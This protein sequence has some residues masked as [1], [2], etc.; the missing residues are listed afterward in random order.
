[1]KKLFIFS[2]LML[3][4]LCFIE[5]YA[6]DWVKQEPYPTFNHLFGVSF[7]SENIGY[8]VG[9]NGTLLKTTDA[10]VTWSQLYI[11]PEQTTHQ[12]S[13]VNF[14]SDDVGYVAAGKL[15]HKTT[16]GGITWESS[17]T[18]AWGTNT[19]TFFIDD[20]V[21]YTYGYYSL[22]YKTMNGGQTWDKLSFSINDLNQ[23]TCVKFADYN[24][25]YLIDY[26]LSGHTYTLKRTDDGGVTWS[27][28]SVPV[29][30]IDVSAVEVL[31]PDNI[32]IASG[33]PFPNPEYYTNA[34]SRV[35][36]TTDGGL[37]WTAHSIGMANSSRPIESIM[38]FN[39]LEGRVIASSHIYTTSD[40]GQTWEDH[41]NYD[42]DPTNGNASVAW[43]NPDTCY[44]AGY[45]PSLLRTYDNGITFEELIHGVENYYECVHFRD[46]LNGY[47][48]GWLSGYAGTPVI[49]YTHDGGNTWTDAE[50]DSVF[51]RITDMH[52]FDADN[53]IAIY[54]RGFYTTN[55]GGYTW[56]VDTLGNE[57]YHILLEVTPDGTLLSAGNEGKIFRSVD[58]G[59]NWEQVFA[60]FI[61]GDLVDFKFTDNLTGFM[62][63]A[64]ETLG[65]QTLY[66]TVDGGFTWTPLDLSSTFWVRS[67]DFYDNLHGMVSMDNDALLYTNDGGL[68]WTETATPLPF[69]ASYIEMFNQLDG[70]VVG[71]GNYVATTNDGGASFQL[72][73]E[74]EYPNWTGGTGY[75][76][77]NMDQGWAV[78][79]QGMILK[80]DSQ[81]TPVYSPRMPYRVAFITPN[82]SSDNIY[83]QIKGELTIRTLTGATLLT[84]K[85]NPND[86][87][88]I[89]HLPAGIYIATVVGIDWSMSMKIIKQ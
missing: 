38:F 36:H 75:S 27:P 45:R 79:W 49:R 2:T 15:V 1:M 69:E 65:P 61:E 33:R 29:E 56:T 66:K 54:A 19:G 50:C 35:Y 43:I 62:A 48:A 70:V 88:N 89:S 57:M 13:N 59:E 8:I 11:Y 32:W 21:G 5:S 85:V 31:G 77:V 76:F 23:Y 67:M 82:P 30:V 9:D 10:G 18:H 4:N 25:G 39:E 24:T 14:L 3:L 12:L 22:L 52:F 40:G 84:T 80:Y 47:A 34:E 46:T 58:N 64:H 71:R 28:V 53:G 86:A 73:Y 20:T 26:R 63:I 37:T 87:I 7:P 55:D 44:F 83:S 81:L 42:I 60:G 72:V 6:Q 74:N 68:T 17:S 41:I 78:G 16:D 51:G